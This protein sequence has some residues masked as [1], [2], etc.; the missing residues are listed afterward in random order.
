MTNYIVILKGAKPDI[1][2]AAV[3]PKGG[4]ELRP[5]CLLGVY[6]DSETA[7]SCQITISKY[8]NTELIE[9]KAIKYFEKEIISD[10]TE[11]LLTE[12]TEDVIVAVKS[13]AKTFERELE[14]NN[15]M[16]YYH[17]Y[18][19]KVVELDNRIKHCFNFVNTKF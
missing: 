1:I 8:T 13:M 17:I 10:D 14:V 12:A 15:I 18:A 2:N 16:K 5:V 6:N 4:I 3:L 7:K 9:V 19:A 11:L